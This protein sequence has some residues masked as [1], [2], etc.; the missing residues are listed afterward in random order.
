MQLTKKQFDGLSDD[1]VRSWCIEAAVGE[2]NRAVDQYAPGC[3]DNSNKSNRVQDALS[4]MR[5]GPSE[6]TLY[7]LAAITH[8]YGKL[9]K[10]E[11]IPIVE[12]DQP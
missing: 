4:Q 9:V 3:S 10:I 6:A 12:E 5:N 1:F 2:A 7:D 11:F 8:S